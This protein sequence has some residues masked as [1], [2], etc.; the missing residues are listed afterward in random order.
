MVKRSLVPILLFAAG[1]PVVVAGGAENPPAPQR[2]HVHVRLG[3]G[4]AKRVKRE[5]PVRILADHAIVASENQPIHMMIGGR[6]GIPGA[7]GEF[8]DFG[9]QVNGKCR[10]VRDGAVRVDLAVTDSGRRAPDDDSLEL[11]SV[12]TRII[13]TIKLGETIV[14]PRP[15][16]GRPGWMEMTV[17]LQHP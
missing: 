3:E 5:G 13:R 6:A 12:S 1:I 7:P 14:V 2:L 16:Y 15:G 10:A 17:D 11:Q 8:V 4:D 9:F